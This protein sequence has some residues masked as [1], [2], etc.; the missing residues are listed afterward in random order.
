MQD[1]R[2]PDR[3]SDW[4]LPPVGDAGPVRVFDTAEAALAFL[5]A[6]APAR[7]DAPAPAGKRVQR[8]LMPTT[9]GGGALNHLQRVY[10]LRRA[11][12]GDLPPARK[13][14][15]PAPRFEPFAKAMLW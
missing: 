10:G 11:A 9:P 13:E 14:A 3:L 15:R 2:W 1:R 12:S 8:R 5:A 6:M 4:V 7:E